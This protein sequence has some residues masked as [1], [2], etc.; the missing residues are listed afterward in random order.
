MIP[1]KAIKKIKN[2]AHRE[3]VAGHLL[4][5][6]LFPSTSEGIAEAKKFVAG[7]DQ[8]I[9]PSDLPNYYA[10]LES[11]LMTGR[12]TAGIVNIRMILKDFYFGNTKDP[13]DIPVEVEVVEVEQTEPDEPIVVKIETPF[14]NPDSPGKPKRV[15]L[16]RIKNTIKK[17]SK[18]VKKSTA[19]RMADAFDKRLDDLVDAIQNPA[20]P[21][22]PK[23]RQQKES[24][25]KIKTAVKPK[26]TFKEIKKPK[27]FENLT[28]FTGLK[29]KSAFGRAAD[30]RRMAQE[31]GL[32][33]QKKGFYATRA[34]GFEFGGDLVA[35]TRGTFS[36]SPDATLDP[37]LSKQ[38]RYTQG[39]FGTRTIRAPKGGGSSGG[40]GSV[41]DLNNSF[42]KLTK[43]FD[44]VINIKKNS[45]TSDREVAEF[46]KVVDELK[47]ALSKGNKLQKE[48]NESKKEQAKI[49]ADAANAAE[50]AAKEAAMEGGDD[51]S[52]FTDSEG[53]VEG[54]KGDGD[55]GG[56]DFN[57]FKLLKNF[58][59][60]N[61]K[62]LLRRIKNPLKT[63]KALKRLMGKKINN[64]L[65]PVKK[66]VENVTPKI[67]KVG[68]VAVDLGKKGV[69]T[70]VDLGTKGVDVAKRGLGAVGGFFKRAGSVVSG[71]A[72]AAMEAAKRVSAWITGKLEAGKQLISKA[73]GELGAFLKKAGM[74]TNWDELATLVRS[75]Q[76]QQVIDSLLGP[77][78]KYVR[79]QI[80]NPKSALK[81]A[82]AGIGNAKVQAAIVKKGGKELLEKVLTKLG[83][84]VGGQAVPAVGQAI[85][86]AYG[87]VEAIARTAMGDPKGGALSLGGA[88]PWA[89]AGFSI[90]DIIRDIDTEAYTKHIEPNLVSIAS[91]NG[92]PLMAFFSDVAGADISG[93]LAAATP[94]PTTDPSKPPTDKPKL[95][96]G[97]VVPAMVGEA[98]PELV[99]TPESGGINP[100][101][102]L[103]PMIVAMR[104]VTKRAGT[105]ADPIENMVRQATD[106]IA[107]QLNLPVLPTKV[108]IGQGSVP[109]LPEDTSKNQR[110]GGGGFGDIMETLAK[111]LG[112]GGATAPGEKGNARPV[113]AGAKGVLDLIASVESNGSYD[114]FNT[115]RGGTPGKAT[116]KTIQWLADNAQGAIGRYQ[117]MP[118][119]LLARAKSAGFGPNTLFTPDV[120]D[121]IT[122]KMLEDGH[123]LKDFLSGKMSA[124]EFAAK[125]APTW[126]G[127]PQ[128]PDAARRLGGTADSTYNDRYAGG[129]KAH[130]KWADSV[131]TLRSI[132]PSATPGMGGPDTADSN[133]LNRKKDKKG[134][135]HNA[136]KVKAI[137]K[138]NTPSSPAPMA[139]PDLDD[140]QPFT[141]VTIPSMAQPPAQQSAMGGGMENMPV[142]DNYSK[143]EQ[144]RRLRLGL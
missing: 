128:G 68:E 30:A 44:E 56:P 93:E 6:G 97:G 77:V 72:G 14:E 73:P 3:I 19:E 87:V 21:A 16:P 144:L 33:E 75:K 79:D 57:P 127:L 125:L 17:V 63:A 22:Q 42:D 60:K 136:I 59:F 45:P 100:L 54:G 38:Q 12:E 129:N 67:K 120:Q 80:T 40:S 123:G 11:D 15:K 139:M 121:A 46:N 65:K 76:A 52:G 107:K 7:L 18:E 91:G 26:S 99:T 51:L 53:L 110:G 94:A 126:R 25:A 39:L 132:K 98:G 81:V 4:A 138:P 140:Q 96:A 78:G 5:Y 66:V 61:L 74:P 102:S 48:I 28:A 111:L 20:E 109:Q 31:Q 71:A 64:A 23:R 106:P 49:A 104:E 32:P 88:I 101:Q 108:D 118:E 103:A 41:K 62:K 92:T 47:D 29:I 24:L 34:L 58:K 116:E 143:I 37:S 137:T 115:S 69:N 95:S 2:D 134:E 8:W 90:V 85:N 36:K 43:K 141:I 130:M 13:D 131:A 113:G 114:V 55:G 119:F 1:Q 70:A 84:K 35:R 83:I 112:G 124:E 122:V 142:V 135:E 117:H 86:I 82:Q 27:I 9:A 133:A 50:A 89:G 10:D 105:W